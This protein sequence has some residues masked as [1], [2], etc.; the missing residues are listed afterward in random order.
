MAAREGDSPTA[1]PSDG[2]GIRGRAFAPGEAHEVRKTGTRGSGAF[3]CK[4]AIG[5]ATSREE[6]APAKRRREMKEDESRDL[7][8][9]SQ[10]AADRRPSSSDGS[11]WN[12]RKALLAS[13]RSGV[14]PPEGL[15]Q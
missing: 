8:H 1:A 13:L 14:R 6:E 9:V 11:Y 3:T 7:K 12:S 5:E 10:G 15:T 4:A 2:R